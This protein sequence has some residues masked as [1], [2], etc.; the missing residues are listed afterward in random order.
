[1]ASDAPTTGARPRAPSISTAPPQ[2]DTHRVN[3][4]SLLLNEPRRFLEQ[5]NAVAAVFNA[6]IDVAEGTLNDTICAQAAG[7]IETL[8][9]LAG[10]AL[11]RLEEN[12][13]TRMA[14][15]L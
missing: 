12:H 14:E 6:S 15:R 3:G 1:M 11:D 4:C 2:I 7:A 8:T 5:A 13:A 9:W 10:F